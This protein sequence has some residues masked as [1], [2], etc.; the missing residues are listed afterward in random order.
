MYHIWYRVFNKQF[1]DINA[2]YGL[3]RNISINIVRYS[4]MNGE[5]S[6]SSDSEELMVDVR[7]LSHVLSIS[8][9][10]LQTV[11]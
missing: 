11:I 1:R 4:L 9:F 5:S 10:L 7:T 6:H 8:T 3:R 2:I